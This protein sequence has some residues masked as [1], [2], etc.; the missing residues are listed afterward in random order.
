MSLC[1]YPRYK[2]SGIDWLGDLPEHWEVRRL[3]TVASYRVSNV[4][5]VP[6][7]EEIPVRLC[8]YTD[9]YYNELIRP[10]MQLME[11][12]AT[13]DEIRRFALQKD[14]VIITKDSEE[15]NDIAVPAL[16]AETAPGVV[17]GYHLAIV[18]RIV[19]KLHGAFLLRL[20]QSPAVNQQFQ[21]AA[22]GVTRYGLP[23]S[24]I[25]DAWLPLPPLDEQKQIAHFL[26]TAITNIAILVQR[27]RAL[28]ERLREKRSALISRVVTRGL[29]PE[30]A[31]AAGLNPQPRPRPSGIDWIGEIPEHWTTP[32]LYS[33]YRV[34]L[35]KMLDENRITG[36][37][38]LSYLRNIDV[39]WDSINVADLPEMDISPVELTRYTIKE[40]DLLVCEGG[41]VGRAAIVPAQAT[42]LGF[43]KALH[44]V[45]PG[46][47]TEVP[48]F[49]YYTLLWASG[50]RVFIADGNPNTISH[51]TA[52][53]LR[54]YRFP[55]PPLA[56]QSSIAE[57]LD[58]ETEKLDNMI[59]KI[60]EATDRLQ[61]YRMAL[62][63]A[64]VTGKVDVREAISASQPEL[65]VAAG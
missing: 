17:C 49:L 52:E 63:T 10:D 62:I 30:A 61:E 56:E 27:K 44:R 58:L 65:L 4:D 36:E 43:Q 5:K 40:G 46:R 23:K 22:T 19:G 47:N 54:R 1:R 24:A 14:D 59:G 42:G 15:W 45:R 28:I 9:V 32:P 41:E 51:L 55:C 8:N 29:P 7:D 18:R 21:L 6:S 20:L 57:F 3:K 60:R 12:T 16:V 2:P 11:S 64:V 53:K 34:D 39:Q 26:R 13:L 37:Y 31:Q 35:G 25:G 33:R 50:S 48:R 38:L